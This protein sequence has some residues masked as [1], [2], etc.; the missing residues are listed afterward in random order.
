[1]GGDI[2]TSLNKEKHMRTLLDTFPGF[3]RF[4][5]GS[6]QLLKQLEQFSNTAAKA[7][8]NYPPYNIKKVDDNKYVIEMAVAGFTRQDVELEMIDG[9]LIV[10]GKLETIDELTKDGDNQTYLYKG[11]SDRAF[12][13][14][15]TLADTVEVK[16]A[17]LLNGMLKIWLEA[18]I[19][20]HKKPT[21]IKINDEKN[22]SSKK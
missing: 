14:Q 20:E 19:P 16:N 3:D 15:F 7:I 4:Y 18:I 22:V 6:D 1:M 21:K 9:K 17:E 8:T 10:K 12:T 5:I 2:L 13:R 11:I